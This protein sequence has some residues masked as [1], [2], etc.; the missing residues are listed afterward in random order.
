[1]VVRLNRLTSTWI[2]EALD[3]EI[4]M[5]SRI[6]LARNIKG[7]PFTHMLED[8]EDME[9]L[10]MLVKKNLPDFDLTLLESE[11]D[12][13]R[14]L[15]AEKH[16]IS[17]K[18][19]R[20][21]TRVFINEDEDISIMLGEEDHL[22]IQA[23]GTNISLEALY[24]KAGAVDDALEAKIE[25]AFDEQYGYLTACPTN[26]G[27]GMRAS[28]M[29]HLPALTA[30]NKIQR[31]HNNLTR[32]G[33]TLRGIYGEGS[34]P[35]GSVFQLS[36][37]VTL[38]FE[39]AVII[40]NLSELKNRL[41]EEER[42]ARQ[43]LMTLD[44]MDAVSRSL[45]ILRHAYKLSLKEAAMHL[46]NVKLGIDLSYIEVDDFNFQEWFQLIQPAFIKE[47]LNN[48]GSHE[49]TKIAAEST[50]AALTRELLGGK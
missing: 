17:P 2:R 38:G 41:I 37:Q 50:R 27:T 1:M 30:T 18:F 31:F 47:R 25:Y 34:E 44:T 6:R 13:D 8:D 36:N 39:E 48:E 14:A 4:E 20:S 29:L 24:E 22:R 40:N 32:F 11:D 7:V 5:S 23:L 33:F 10:G 19:A 12:L 35:L 16:L 43:H 21:G 28:V 15:L 9:A 49:Y 45:G 46:S 42:L 26:V 3:T